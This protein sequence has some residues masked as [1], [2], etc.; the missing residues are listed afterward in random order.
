[1][2]DIP[3]L[4][5]NQSTPEGKILAP[6]QTRIGVSDS[7]CIGSG[8]LSNSYKPQSAVIAE[9]PSVVASLNDIDSGIL[10][11]R[12]PGTRQYSENAPVP[13]SWKDPKLTEATYHQDLK[14][15]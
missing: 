5:E 13:G 3:T 4:A 12:P 9:A 15:H 1:M 7:G 10:K 6:D 11:A 2:A 8:S 14:Q